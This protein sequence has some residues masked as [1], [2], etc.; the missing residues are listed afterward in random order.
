MSGSPRDASAG[1]MFAEKLK[2]ILII[3]GRDL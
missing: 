2:L 3:L 1:R